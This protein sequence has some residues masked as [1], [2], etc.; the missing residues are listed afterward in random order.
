MLESMSRVTNFDMIHDLALL[1]LLRLW[2]PHE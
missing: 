2:E 1:C